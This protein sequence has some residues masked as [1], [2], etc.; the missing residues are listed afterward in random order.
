MGC[1]SGWY[2]IRSI[3]RCG[4]S[5]ETSKSLKQT[6]YIKGRLQHQSLTDQCRVLTKHTD[7]WLPGW[8]RCPG[9]GR[10]HPC[11]SS[12]ADPDTPPCW[13]HRGST[14]AELLPYHQTSTTPTSASSPQL[15]VFEQQLC[16]LPE[17]SRHGADGGLLLSDVWFVCSRERR[18][19]E[20]SGEQSVLNTWRRSA[21]WKNNFHRKCVW[22]RKKVTIR[23]SWSPK[24][25]N[26]R[27]RAAKE[28][29]CYF[30]EQHLSKTQFKVHYRVIK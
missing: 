30:S 12:P 9:S 3:T 21:E 29:F 18:R 2:N 19:K 26:S 28:S 17:A 7:T 8:S 15:H 25:G 14:L 10:L 16:I 20:T 23:F 5:C 1:C 11:S 13:W 4:G 22:V 24:E 27:V 6:L